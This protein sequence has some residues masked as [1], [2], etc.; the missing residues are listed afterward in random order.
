ML[1]Y[2]FVT[3]QLSEVLRDCRLNHRVLCDH[4]GDL[5]HADHHGDLIHAD[6]HGD[7]IRAY[8]LSSTLADC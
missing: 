7:L 4:H 1:L 5:I 8:R 3:T 2:N 6:N